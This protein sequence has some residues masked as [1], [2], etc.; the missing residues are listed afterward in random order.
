MSLIT[1]GLIVLLAWVFITFLGTTA[2]PEE[3]NDIRS[4][5]TNTL[6]SAV[7]YM[8]IMYACM[9]FKSDAM[10][11]V[12]FVLLGLLALVPFIGAIM[13]IVKH[14][15]SAK[16]MISALVSS[17]VPVFID[18]CILINCILK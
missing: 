15:C 13:L 1:I 12:A 10:D 17:L 8:A 9:Y 18:I 2:V 11:W 4:D 7:G 3:R 16:R 6:L 14:E 5:G